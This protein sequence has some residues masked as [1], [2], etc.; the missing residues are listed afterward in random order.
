MKRI[1]AAAISFVML[2]GVLSG[3]T[4]ESP[5]PSGNPSTGAPSGVKTGGT[6]I[7]GQSAEPI[8]LNPNGKIDSNFDAVA[9]NIFSRLL[10]TNNNQ[11]VILDLAT[12]YTVSENGLEYTFTLPAKVNFHDGKPLTSA[13]VKFTFEEIVKQGGSAAGS[14]AGITEITCPDATTVIF[15]LAA[16]DSSFLGA[17]AYNGAFILPK[18]VYEGK[19]WLDADAL[20]TPVGSGSFK[21]SD[22]QRGVKLE[23]V[24]NEDYYLGKQYPYLDKL[25]YSYISD[26]NTAMQSFYNAELDVLGII[27]PATEYEKLLT[28]TNIVSQ[29]VIYPSRF[30]VGFN[31]ATDL[32]KDM[33]FRLAVAHAMDS[34]DLIA[35][36]LK[37]IGLQ[38]EFY[39]SPLYDWAVN[40][41]DSARVPAYNLET[42]KEYMAKTGLTA[43]SKGIYAKIELDTYNYEPFPDLAQV[44]KSQLAEIGI[45]LTI[46]MLEYGAWDEKVRVNKNY[47]L[48]LGGGYQGPEAGNLS[49]YV[50]SDGF[51]NCFNY[52]NSEIDRLFAEGASLPTFELRAPK[53][54]EAQ[55]ILADDLPFVLISEWLGY[56]PYRS[57]IKGHPASPEAVGKT[58]FGEFTFMWIDK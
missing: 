9:Q 6:A 44:L 53:Y 36:A 16:V 38:A 26:S 58:A 34:S 12:G 3:C 55:Q 31:Q 51:S 14:F 46:N 15:K 20:M 37:R 2:L 19:D 54:K 48:T 40:K 33:N 23:L 22:W 7:V 24:R 41:S 1:I 42:A 25:V 18:H 5:S 4:S 8:T 17:L 10:K 13:D 29:K 21:Y 52:S 50:V 35:K 56:I 32:G 57:Y 47:T 49:G 30:Y 43:D 39:M 45:E 11:D 28:D 27:A